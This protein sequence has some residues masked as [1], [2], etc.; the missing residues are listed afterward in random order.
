MREI[1][2]RAKD[3]ISNNWIYSNGYYFDGI[4]YWF[5][6]PDKNPS[7][8]ALS[9]IDT[10]PIAFSHQ[11]LVLIETLGQCIGL[12]DVNGNDVYEGDRLGGIFGDC[13][14]DYCEKCKSPQ[15]IMEDFGCSGCNRDVLWDEVFQ[16]DGKLTVI[17]NIHETKPTEKGE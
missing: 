7:K 4:N 17:G 14:I 2:L 12:K 11:H 9:D 15:L 16:Y 6:L 5:T 13:W 3:K 1:K 10:Y 8:G